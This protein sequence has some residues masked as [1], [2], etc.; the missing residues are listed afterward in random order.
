MSYGDRLAISVADLHFLDGNTAPLAPDIEL[1]VT[2]TVRSRPSWSI[3]LHDGAARA[4]TAFARFFDQ[5]VYLPVRSS[6]P[7]D[8][9]ELQLSLLRRYTAAARRRDRRSSG[10][11]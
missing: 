8:G 6:D 4:S 11:L 3:K 9:P 2:Y 10:I 5:V 7:R 1:L